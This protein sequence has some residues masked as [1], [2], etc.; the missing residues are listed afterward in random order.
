MRFQGSLSEQR[1]GRL[2]KQR[3][4]KEATE[5][6]QRNKDIETEKC[7]QEDR[8]VT[9][10]LSTGSHMTGRF[11]ISWVGLSRVE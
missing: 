4:G 8:A 1:A 6:C 3:Q 11:G 10:H 7:G 5:R 2:D 9:C